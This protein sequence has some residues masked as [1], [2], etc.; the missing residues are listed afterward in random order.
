MMDSNVYT[1]TLYVSI[2]FNIRVFVLLWSLDSNEI[3]FKS[4]PSVLD[5]NNYYGWFKNVLIN[6]LVKDFLNVYDNYRNGSNMFKGTLL[7]EETFAPKVF[8]IIR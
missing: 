5:F 4:L 1:T 6:W 3:I 2:M 8:F 7:H